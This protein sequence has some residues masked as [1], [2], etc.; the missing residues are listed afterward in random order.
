MLHSAVG[1][2]GLLPCCCLAAL[3]GIINIHTKISFGNFD[4]LDLRDYFDRAQS[5]EFIC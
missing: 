2:Q 3:A 4:M 1:G 5:A